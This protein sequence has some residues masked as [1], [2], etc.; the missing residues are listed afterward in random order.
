MNSADKLEKGGFN[1]N[2][3]SEIELSSKV[4]NDDLD[5]L[6]VASDP[7]STAN[8]AGSRSGTTANRGPYGAS[9]PGNKII[10]VLFVTP[11]PR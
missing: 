10:F 2:N 7:A 4:E 9:R 11:Q 8:S 3:M 6:V 5:P 1:A